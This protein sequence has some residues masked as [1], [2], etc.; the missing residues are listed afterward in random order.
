MPCQQH[1]AGSAQPPAL[2]LHLPAGARDTQDT[3]DDYDCSPFNDL[4]IIPEEATSEEYSSTTG[5]P[6][7][8]SGQGSGASRPGSFLASEGAPSGGPAQQR[9][10]GAPA[11]LSHPSGGSERGGLPSGGSNQL[12]SHAL[13]AAGP[14]PDEV[15]LELLQ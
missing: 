7:S 8:V 11:L 9:S 14:R 5:G 2:P 10:F 4:C 15:K 13:P 1:H 12:R 3:A 6:G